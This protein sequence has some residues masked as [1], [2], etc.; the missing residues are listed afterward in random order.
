MKNLVKTM[1]LK[2]TKHLEERMNERNVNWSMINDTLGKHKI[3]AGKNKET[4]KLVGRTCTVV[5]TKTR[6]LLTAY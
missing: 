5:I 4:I 2:I 3:V 6:E 1:N